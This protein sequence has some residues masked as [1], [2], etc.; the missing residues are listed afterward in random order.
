ML[1]SREALFRWGFSLTAGKNVHHWV[2]L[3]FIYCAN[4]DLKVI[5]RALEELVWLRTR[6]DYDL[7]SPLFAS[8]AKA[9]AAI[10][11]AASALALLDQIEADPARRAVAISAIRP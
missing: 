3:C 11:Q 1:E 9:R 5:G 4:A 10:Q 6:A 2:R 8:A 7:A